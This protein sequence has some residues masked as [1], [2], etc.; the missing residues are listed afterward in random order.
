MPTPRGRPERIPS[1][2]SSGTELA[3]EIGAAEELRVLAALNR[4]G[5]DL[6]EPIE[7]ERT[8]DSPSRITVTG[9]GINTARQADVR[10]AVSGLQGVELRF[11]E[12]STVTMPAGEA[13]RA[14]LRPQVGTGGLVSELEQKLGR[15]EE[16]RIIVDRVLDQSDSSLIRAHALDKL[17]RRFPRIV[18]AGLTPADRH[19]LVDLWTKHL[20]AMENSRNILA[21]DLTLLRKAESPG[22]A[23]PCFLAGVH[24]HVIESVAGSGPSTYAIA[25]GERRIRWSGDPKCVCTLAVGAGRLPFRA[26]EMSV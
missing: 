6:G 20:Q 15:P 21:K 10:A 17:A 14:T 2:A 22:V 12:P 11:V 23:Q 4:I 26:G 13:P 19:T 1:L 18:E 16:A 24:T 7:V 8:S 5:A 25:G 9:L 3:T